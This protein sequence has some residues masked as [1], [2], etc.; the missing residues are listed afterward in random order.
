MTHPKLIKAS[1]GAILTVPTFEFSSVDECYGWLSSHGF[2][3]YLAD[4][5]APHF[6]YDEPFGRNTA[7][8]VGSER[9][10]I[11]REWYEKEYS[12]IAIP[13][14]GKCDSLNVGVAATVLTYEACIKNKLRN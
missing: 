14:L 7:L 12:M 10:G 3:V 2:T 6:H 5:R 13:M 11:A 4:T 9:Y 8:I 1:Q